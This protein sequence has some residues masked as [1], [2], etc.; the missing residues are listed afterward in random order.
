[1]REVELKSVVDDVAMRRRAAADGGGSL[2]FE[3]RLEDRRYDTPDGALTGRDEVLRTRTYR[4]ADGETRTS[5]DWKGPRTIEQGY[6]V[7]EEQSITVD[8]LET[9]ELMLGRLGFRVTKAIDRHII[10]FDL[11]GAVVRFERYPRMD[12]LV[13]VEG[14]PSAIERA[15]ALLGMQRAEFN[16]DSLADFARRYEKRTGVAA[17][18]SDADLP[19]DSRRV[20]A[21]G[22]DTRDD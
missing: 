17:A 7:R 20:Q 1:M 12:D 4:V 15:I 13:E 22:D 6:R 9:L 3:G 16:G 18:L 21:D 11:H 2:V 10:Q 19:V 5:L 8:S 14:E